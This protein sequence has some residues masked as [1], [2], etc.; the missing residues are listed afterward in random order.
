M[1]VLR[2]CSDSEEEDQAKTKGHCADKLI[3][4]SW[5]SSRAKEYVQPWN[6]LVLSRSRGLRNAR[7]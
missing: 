6:P 3:R 4:I 7:F 2:A 5:H 1:D